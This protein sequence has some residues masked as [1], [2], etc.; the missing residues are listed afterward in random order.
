MSTGW[1]VA[2]AL[3]CVGGVLSLT[4]AVVTYQRTGSLAYSKIVL[5]FGVPAMFYAIARSA[6]GA[7]R[8]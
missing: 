6:Q 4:N 1:K 2:L 8:G 3:A 5:A 7:K